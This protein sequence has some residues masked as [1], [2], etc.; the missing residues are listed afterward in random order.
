MVY[1]GDL[2]FWGLTLTV[3]ALLS[4]FFRMHFG[5][6]YL[7]AVFVVWLIALHYAPIEI[8]FLHFLPHK[9]LDLLM[10]VCAELFKCCFNI[11]VVS[12][13]ILISF[14]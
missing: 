14:I 8:S 7:S 5:R 12:V 4:V 2:W 13:F 10:I 3:T 11:E 9:R 1:L 6:F